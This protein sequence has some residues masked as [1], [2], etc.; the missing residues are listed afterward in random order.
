MSSDNR[1]MRQIRGLVNVRMPRRR[2]S[3][4]KVGVS[5]RAVQ[6]DCPLDPPSCTFLPPT[7][8]SIRFVCPPAHLV[9]WTKG[10]EIG[11]GVGVGVGVSVGLGVGL[12]FWLSLKMP[13][14]A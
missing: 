5:R 8:V 9:G 6:A 10:K 7:K 12:G 3:L 2:S 13:F 4:G 1:A 14:K 11:L